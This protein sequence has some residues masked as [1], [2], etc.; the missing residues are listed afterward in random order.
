MNVWWMHP[1]LLG[2]PG[3]GLGYMKPF[4]NIKI[5]FIIPLKQQFL[6]MVVSGSMDIYNIHIRI[7]N[8]RIVYFFYI[9]RDNWMVSPDVRGPH[10]IY[11]V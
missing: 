7:C 10:G 6:Q 11:C 9:S 1:R 3:G 5:C 2:G 8:I 4:F